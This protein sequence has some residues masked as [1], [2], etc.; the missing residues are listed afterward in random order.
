MPENKELDIGISKYSRE[1]II[2]HLKYGFTHDYLEEV[3]FEKRLKVALNTQS[4]NDLMVLVEDLP[5]F[6]EEE[7]KEGEKTT[8]LVE[9][10]KGHIK[11]KDSII[12]ILGGIERKGMWKPAKKMDV[13]TVLGGTTLDF[14]KA[15]FPPGIIEINMFCV[16]GGVDIIVPH[17]VNVNNQCIAI[18]G[19]SDDRSVQGENENGPTLRITGS[20]VMGGLDIKTPKEGLMTRILKKLGI[21]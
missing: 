15:V 11:E 12:S 6:K 7:K 20:V 8:P 10:N 5:E 19:G 21:D 4:R 18:L 9:I 1:K 16:M 14:T 3:D 17:G 13:I 2:E